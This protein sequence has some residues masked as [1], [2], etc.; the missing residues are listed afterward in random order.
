M[1]I[2]TINQL[3]VSLLALLFIIAILHSALKFL[4]QRFENVAMIQKLFHMM[5]FL[6]AA[7]F[8]GYIIFFIWAVKF[9]TNT[10]AYINSLKQTTFTGTTDT[11]G[12]VFGKFYG[13]QEWSVEDL[14]DP[15]DKTHRLVIM[16]GQCYKEIAGTT[17]ANLVNVEVW[18]DASQINKNYM[19]YKFLGARVNN[20]ALSDEDFNDLIYDTY[21]SAMD[22]SSMFR[23]GLEDGLSNFASLVIDEMNR[24]IYIGKYYS[25][26]DERF[27]SDDNTR[28]ENASAPETTSSA[29]NISS[30]AASGHAD[31]TPVTTTAAAVETTPAPAETFAQKTFS[32][33]SIPAG[34]EVYQAIFK[35]SE[36]QLCSYYSSTTGEYLIPYMKDGIPTVIFSSASTMNDDALLYYTEVTDISE[37]EYGGITYSADIYSASRSVKDSMGTIHITWDSVESLDFA[38]V[39]LTDGN[40]MSD[41]DMVANDY[42]Y[43][44]MLPSDSEAAE[45]MP[46]S[47][48]TFS[49]NTNAGFPIAG[50]DYSYSGTEGWF[51]FVSYSD[52]TALLNYYIGDSITRPQGYDLYVQNSVDYPC[53][54]DESGD[55]LIWFDASGASATI[56]RYGELS[57]YSL[58]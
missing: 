49:G 42:A 45:A 24:S 4:H 25:Y 33:D 22:Q 37:T 41:T 32:A 16:S 44:S 17:D 48:Q 51:N 39:T 29:G 38:E 6:Y 35:A 20:A 31:S 13:N 56:S 18:F 30:Y 54:K 53:Y 55:Y 57:S 52:G 15:N 46:D 9:K 47:A 12:H 14:D 19:Q 36:I 23:G 5:K 7:I 27:S 40:Q 8:L 10:D 58:N 43:D 50:E 34:S 3:A 26:Y 28:S 11:V 1:D 21:G 2:E